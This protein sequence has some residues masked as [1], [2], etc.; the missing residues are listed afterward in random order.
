MGRLSGF[1]FPKFTCYEDKILIWQK[2]V[3][4]MVVVIMAAGTVGCTS[5]STVSNKIA[6]RAAFDLDCPEKEIAVTL[7]E[8]IASSG[9]YGAVGCGKRVRYEV[10]C[11]LAMSNCSI[12]T[13]TPSSE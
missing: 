1:D 5:T 6:P 13:V 9:S 12:D 10:I 7:I 4:S 11:S 3:L 8:G 2:A